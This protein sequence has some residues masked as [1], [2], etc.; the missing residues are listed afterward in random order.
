MPNCSIPGCVGEYKSRYNGIGY[1]ARHFMSVYMRD[2]RPAPKDARYFMGAYGEAAVR[3]IFRLNGRH[4]EDQPFKC[5]FDFRVDGYRIEVKTQNPL[6]NGNWNM[7]VKRK[8][9]L[10]EHTDFYVFRLESPLDAPIHLLVRGPIGRGNFYVCRNKLHAEHAKA[11][12]DF[13]AFARGTFDAREVA[14]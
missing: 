12:A 5:K 2:H 3:E 9:I 14:A 6:R 4:V 10:D 1:C 7:N 13:Y 11:I 8:G